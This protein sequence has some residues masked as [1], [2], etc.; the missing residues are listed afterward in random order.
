MDFTVKKY[1]L[2]LNALKNANYNFQTFAEFL[3]A[4]GERVVILRHDVDLMPKNSLRFAKIQHE[5]G[6][7]GSYYFR[8]VP[9]SWD[10]RIIKEIASL[11]HEI[12]YHYENLTTCSGDIEK[13]LLNFKDNLHKLR[14]LAPVSTICMHGSP[15]SKY[16][17]RDL[18]NDFNYKDL[19]L[20]G[21]P[22][23][24]VDFN[25]VFYLTDTGRRWDGHR[26]SVRDKVNTNFDQTF[27]STDEIIEA[28]EKDKLPNVIMFTFHPQRWND[29]M[30][31]WTKELILQNLKNLVKR[32]L[33]VNR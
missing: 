25:Q 27:H 33:Y 2:L 4:P 14:E 24:D 28:L 13:A 21:E 9:E 20:I 31:Y 18:W 3:E 19:G 30:F 8:A 1:R 23:F 17:S 26:V 16:D 22:Y 12:G 32:A 15:M 11:N 10:D 29:N 7:S 5:H 6:A